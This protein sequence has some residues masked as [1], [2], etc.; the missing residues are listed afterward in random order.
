MLMNKI[1]DQNEWRDIV[2]SWVD[3]FNIANVPIVHKLTNRFNVI[4]I[5]IPVGYFLYIDNLL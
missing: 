4:L 3:I 1:K 2:Y 5:K